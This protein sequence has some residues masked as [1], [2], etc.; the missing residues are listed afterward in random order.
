MFLLEESGKVRCGQ[1]NELGSTAL[2]DRVT[3]TRTC[4]SFSPLQASTE[5]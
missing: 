5:S 4:S 3:R 2:L 1:K